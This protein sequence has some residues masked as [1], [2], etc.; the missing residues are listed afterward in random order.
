MLGTWT[1]GYGLTVYAGL[2][3]NNPGT[4]KHLS[5]DERNT[6]DYSLFVNSRNFDFYLCLKER[7]QPIWSIEG[8]HS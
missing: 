4:A 1:V 8:K 7:P 6:D 3:L 2:V 5:F